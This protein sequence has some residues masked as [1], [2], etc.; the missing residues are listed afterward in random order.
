MTVALSL[1]AFVDG[2]KSTSF[3]LIFKLCVL[4]QT[5]VFGHL[6]VDFVFSGGADVVAIKLS[7]ILST[8]KSFMIFFHVNFRTVAKA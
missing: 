3:K 2:L 7:H 5:L 4:H 8:Q 6:K 1:M